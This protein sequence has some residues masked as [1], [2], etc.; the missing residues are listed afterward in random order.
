[1]IFVTVGT[2]HGF[3]RL[4]KGVD[5]L[6]QRGTI[7]D[8]VYAQVGDGLYRPKNMD[9]V[10]SLARDR[11][12]AMCLEATAIVSHAGMGIISLALE[13]RKPIL[14]MP[15]LRKYGEVV[16]DHQLAI[17]ERFCELGC[18]LL[19][20]DVVDLE[21]Q[22]QRLPDF[23][24]CARSVRTEPLVA[25]ILAYLDEVQKLMGDSN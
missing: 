1:V 11:F 17:A 5:E 8:R 9:Y 23:T 22:I 2:T 18:L 25:R 20:K 14:V 16:S 21:V 3:D 12:Q 19:A 24:P 13:Y 6:V 4:V 7:R 15:R 10:H